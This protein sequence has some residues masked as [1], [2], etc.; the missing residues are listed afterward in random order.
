MLE[1]DPSAFLLF[2]EALI[3]DQEEVTILGTT[4]NFSLLAATNENTAGR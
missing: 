3:L 4:G 1:G 2:V